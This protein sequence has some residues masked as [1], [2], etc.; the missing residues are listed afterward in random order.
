MCCSCLF[1]PSFFLLSPGELALGV[2]HLEEGGGAPGLGGGGGG[3]SSL[4]GGGGGGVA[5]LEQ[6]PGAVQGLP[7]LSVLLGLHS[8][9]LISA[10]LNYALCTMQFGLYTRETAPH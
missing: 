2:E 7:H 9:V 6:A 8:L 10:L 3:D 1:F 5:L 4:G